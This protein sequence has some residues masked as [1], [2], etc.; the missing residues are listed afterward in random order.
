LV[1]ES[2]EKCSE[3]IGFTVGIFHG[4][5]GKPSDEEDSRDPAC[6]VARLCNVGAKLFTAGVGDEIISDVGVLKLLSLSGLRNR[7]RREGE[8]N[9][10]ELKWHSTL[11]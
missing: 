7:Q 1:D 9:D 11:Q 10:G 4:V 8:K 2:P 6:N 3:P 5:A